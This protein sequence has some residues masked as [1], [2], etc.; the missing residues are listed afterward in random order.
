MKTFK[1]E[2]VFEIGANNGYQWC[3]CD[4]CTLYSYC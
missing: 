1:L 4:R 3:K 2:F